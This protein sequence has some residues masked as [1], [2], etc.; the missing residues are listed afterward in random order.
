MGGQCWCSVDQG[1]ALGGAEACHAGVAD[2]L[3][4][5]S[6]LDTEHG[7]VANLGGGMDEL[8]EII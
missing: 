1:E 5:V 3:G 7:N 2:E 4:D 8:G 6:A